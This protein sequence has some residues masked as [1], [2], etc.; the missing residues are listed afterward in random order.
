MRSARM[1]LAAA[2]ATAALAIAAPGAYAATAGDWDHSDSSSS[3]SSSSSSTKDHE[4]SGYGKEH[5]DSGYGQD[6]GK[7]SDSDHGKPSWHHEKPEGGVHTGG[8]ALMS[9]KTDDSSKGDKKYDPETYKDKDSSSSDHGSGS[10][11]SGSD[12]GSWDSGSKE[13]EKP[14][15]G[16]HTGGGGLATSS[17]V[18]AG[19]IG[20]LGLAA[21]GVYMLRRRNTQ[22]G[23]A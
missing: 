1:L 2:T 11:D 13:E 7:D 3:S 12:K 9:I 4:D 22:G 8:G 17:G 15:G 14:H 5:D 10:W 21:A 6:H 18:T 20:V 19:G 23:V 16:M